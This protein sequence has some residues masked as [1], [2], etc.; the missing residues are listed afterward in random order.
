MSRRRC[1][2][3]FVIVA[4]A[5]CGSPPP[6]A[7]MTPV[8]PVAP[9]AAVAVAAAPAVNVDGAWHGSIEAGGKKLRLVVHL[10]RAADGLHATLDSPDQGAKGLPVTSATF[11][12]GTLT[13]TLDAFHAGYVGKLDG[14]RFTGTWTQG[15][16]ALPLALD[17]GEPAKPRRPQEPERP[18]AYTEQDVSISVLTAPR[19]ANARRPDAERITLTGTLTLPPGDGPFPA[20]LMITGSGPQDRDET[21]FDHRPFLVLSDALTRRGIA[22]LRFDDRGVGTSGGATVGA[23]TLDLAEDAIKELD[24]LAGQPKID[25]RAVGVLGHSEGGVIGPIVAAR[26]PHARFVVMLA[27]TGLPGDQVLAEQS[28]LISRAL[29]EPEDRV[30]HEIADETALYKKIRAA[31]TD[32]QAEAAFQAFVDA[33][34]PSHDERAAAIA[35][36]KSR[37]SWF[38]VFFSID[39]STYLAKLRVPV[40]AISGEK[41]LQ[42]PKDN[43]PAIEKALGRGHNP[44]PTVKMMPGLNHLFQHAGTGA[45]SEYEANEETFAPEALQLVVDWIAERTAKMRR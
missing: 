40:L 22:T 30:T 44:D 13:L 1:G 31:T 39:P 11:E 14:D 2:S 4:A 8:A 10:E 17:H 16:H 23:T 20:V 42:V 21:V 18:F 32:A 3:V 26:D 24:W 25:R 29:G 41:D 34:P 7:A 33:Y 15:G 38:H 37:G 45:P 27:G 12:A 35:K 9:V 36:L 6:P 28:A 43:L 5:A 19:A